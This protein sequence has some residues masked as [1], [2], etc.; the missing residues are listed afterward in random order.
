MQNLIPLILL[1]LAAAILPAPAAAQERDKAHVGTGASSDG[2]ASL[3]GT[4]IDSGVA[5]PRGV[6]ET[7][8]RFRFERRLP[9]DKDGAPT[10]AAKPRNSVSEE[11]YLQDQEANRKRFK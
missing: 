6:D 3:G 8:K 1:G 11:A 4:G 7:D 10:G 9:P 5:N 2:G